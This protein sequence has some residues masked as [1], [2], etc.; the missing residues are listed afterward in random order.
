MKSTK[1]D[2]SLTKDH[3][4]TLGLEYSAGTDDIRIAFRTLAA[5]CHPDRNPGMKAREQFLEIRAAYE[6]LIDPASR[7]VYLDSLRHA[8]QEGRPD[9]LAAA[10]WDGYLD[11]IIAGATDAH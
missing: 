7:T 2:P 5:T 9:E 4:Q 11:R 3:Y 6:A 1:G 10:A 8:V